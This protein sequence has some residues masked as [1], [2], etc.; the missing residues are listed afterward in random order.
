MNGHS[1]EEG[2]AIRIRKPKPED[3]PAIWQLLRR[4]ESLEDN[5]RDAY[6][7]L[8]SHFANTSLV[9][10]LADR[11]VAFVG[12]YRPPPN[13]KTV[14]VWQIGVDAALRR[15]GLG[16]ALLRVLI[17]CPGCEGVEYLEATVGSSNAASKRL[18]E[19]FA[20]DIDAP[21]D[22][23]T[24]FSSKPVSPLQDEN[25]DLLRIGPIEATGD[26]SPR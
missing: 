15:H 22:L 6:L 1:R 10:H 5:T 14:F 2:L 12:A 3:G 20:R 13:S 18:F 8:A 25:E 26:R 24:G 21:C 11:V 4:S 9:A 17:R 23:T 7:L 19:G 16:N